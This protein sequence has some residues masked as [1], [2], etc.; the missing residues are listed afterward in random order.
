MEY[1]APEKSSVW[2]FQEIEISDRA[3][4]DIRD[5]NIMDI[6][7]VH[8]GMF[9]VTREPII[10]L[11]GVRVEET[12]SIITVK[13]ICQNFGI[14]YFSYTTDSDMMKNPDTYLTKII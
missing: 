9:M 6:T 14:G 13:I 4:I 5:F 7:K 3:P 1:W 12:I 2:K 8:D 10:T 11:S